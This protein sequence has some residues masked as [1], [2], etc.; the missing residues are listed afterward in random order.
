MSANCAGAFENDVRILPDTSPPELQRFAEW[1][2]KRTSPLHGDDVKLTRFQT[3]RPRWALQAQR[4]SNSMVVKL[5]NC[6]GPH[7]DLVAAILEDF[8]WLTKQA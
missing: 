3:M 4:L 6:E 2:G 1:S 8:A 7:R 5:K